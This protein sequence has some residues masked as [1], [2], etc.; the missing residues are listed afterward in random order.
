MAHGCVAIVLCF[1][2]L[3]GRPQLRV[4]RSLADT[5][6]SLGS[7]YSP[8][9]VRVSLVGVASGQLGTRTPLPYGACT[10][11]LFDK[12]RRSEDHMQMLPPAQ[13]SD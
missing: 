12:R 10:T 9:V 3:E 6:L 2:W 5:R 7:L 11:L 1:W 8:G 13:S 4:L